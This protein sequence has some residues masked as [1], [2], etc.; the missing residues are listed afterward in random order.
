MGIEFNGQSGNE[1]LSIQLEG[2]GAGSAN[3]VHCG[4]DG[5]CFGPEPS[6]D[7]IELGLTV[8]GA[9]A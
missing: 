7:Q 1:K 9:R 2:K 8:P 5:A 4:Y 6:Q 3:G